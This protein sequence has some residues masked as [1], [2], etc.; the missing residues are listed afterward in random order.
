ML[1]TVSES[2]TFESSVQAENAPSFIVLSPFGSDTEVIPVPENA[3]SPISV[4]VP[5]R[6]TDVTDAQSAKLAEPTFVIPGAYT[7]EVI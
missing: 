5:A 2:E 3:S 7:T 6:V 1:V 4:T